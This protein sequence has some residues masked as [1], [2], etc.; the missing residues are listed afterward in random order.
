MSLYLPDYVGEA[1]EIPEVVSEQIRRFAAKLF[2]NALLFKVKL[3]P[4]FISVKPSVAPHKSPHMVLH[5]KT[6]EQ[7]ALPEPLV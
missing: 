3:F 6:S 2:H 1:K 5:L 4:R 7:Q